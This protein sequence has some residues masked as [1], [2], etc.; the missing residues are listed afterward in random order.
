MF[1]SNLEGVI[2]LRDASYDYNKGNPVPIIG[3]SLFR[4][5]FFRTDDYKVYKC[6]EIHYGIDDFPYHLQLDFLKMQYRKR[7]RKRWLPIP[8]L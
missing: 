3:L 6:I 2:Q 5:T 1:P 4:A 7:L 8:K